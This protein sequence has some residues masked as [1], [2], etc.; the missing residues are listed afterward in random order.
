MSND[1]L[2]QQLCGIIAPM[3]PVNVSRDD[4]TAWAEMIAD[5]VING[6]GLKIEW[7]D[8]IA[9]TLGLRPRHRWATG[10]VETREASWPD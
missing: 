4:A 1:E 5:A 6:L 8:H 3:M 9:H 10:W 7:A 2:R